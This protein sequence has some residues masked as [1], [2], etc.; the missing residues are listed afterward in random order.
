MS[1][2]VAVV[3]ERHVLIVAVSAVVIILGLS[4]IAVGLLTYGPVR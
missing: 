2:E 4:L 1:G 3:S